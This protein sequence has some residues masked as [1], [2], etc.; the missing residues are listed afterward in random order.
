MAV[1]PSSLWDGLRP[2]ML[3][4]SISSVLLGM[5]TAH[6]S[7]ASWLMADGLLL[8]LGVVLAHAGFNLF[9]SYQDVVSGFAS[10]AT[11]MP[12]SRPLTTSKA[13]ADLLR[14]VAVGL[15]FIA[16][17]IGAYFVNKSGPALLIP[18]IFTLLMVALYHSWLMRNPHLN[19]ILP[20]VMLGPVLV[21]SC[22]FILTG[23][24]SF[25]ALHASLASFFLVNNLFL[26]NQYPNYH[27]NRELGRFYFPVMYGTKR[28]S[29]VYVVFALGVMYVIG[30]GDII[31]LLAEPVPWAMLP[32]LFSL[33]AVVGGFK[34]GTDGDK[35]RPHLWANMA[36]TL[37]VTLMLA[38]LMVI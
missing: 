7:G 27:L 19:L 26:L 23:E 34:Y 30:M 15:L 9:T 10:R 20:G 31:G 3:L 37:L 2:M 17:V 32:L 28:S 25:F 6:S 24:Y 36:A 16:L 22:H 1:K 12:F 18:I 33:Y 4:V 13:D 38:Y 14:R 8:V 35:L 5:A 11:A 21:M 29:V